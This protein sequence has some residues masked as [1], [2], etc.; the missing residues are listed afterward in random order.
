MSAPQ[1]TLS[2]VSH[3]QN[4][5]VNALLV[6]LAQHCAESLALVITQNVADPIALETKRWPGIVEVLTNPEPKGFGANHNAAFERCRTQY[7][8]VCNPDIRL[9]ADP[10]PALLSTLAGGEVGV[11]GPIVRDPSGAIEDSARR[12]PTPWRL[13]RKAWL[14]PRGPDYD[15]SAG[16]IDVDWVAGMFMIFPSGTFRAV[17]GFDEGYFLYYEDVDICRALH[18]AGMHVVYDPRAAVVHDARRQ[19]RRDLALARHHVAS[20]LRFL[21]GPEHVRRHTRYFAMPVDADASPPG[22]VVFLHLAETG[23]TRLGE[24]FRRMIPEPG[25]LK[26]QPGGQASALGTWPLDDVIRALK[27]RP[28]SLTPSLRYVG[29]HLGFGVHRV[30]PRAARYVTLI[31]DPVDRLLSGFFYSIGNHRAATGED[32]SLADYVFRK[33][34]C[35][36]GLDNY[37]ARVLSGDPALDAPAGT[38]TADADPVTEEAFRRLLDN[39]G[40]HLLLVG[41]TERFDE[42][43][44]L[45]ALRMGWDVAALA[46][47]MRNLTAGRPAAAEIPRYVV[48]EIERRNAYDRRLH[49]WASG[50]MDLQIRAAGTAFDAALERLRAIRRTANAQR[51]G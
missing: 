30:L 34:H 46:Y 35:D 1:V 8:C 33:R 9:A 16:P 7:F 48:A 45:L 19:S 38:M 31:R 17:G 29:G 6:D 5:L 24:L 47:V 3:S 28:E 12:F 43:L 25:Q 2:V 18:I 27:V 10:F 42:F 26:I 51:P 44:V 41:V 40:E 49:R 21:R 36:L 15:G 11:V 37:Q 32:V 13:L 22:M 50:Q 20:I 14:A 23:G 39:L 4:A